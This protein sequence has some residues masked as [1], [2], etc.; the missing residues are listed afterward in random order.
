MTPAHVTLYPKATHTH[1]HTHTQSHMHPCPH[2]CRKTSSMLCVH[3]HRGQMPSISVNGL[4]QIAPQPS[5]AAG[6]QTAQAGHDPSKEIWPIQGAALITWVDVLV[7]GG[8]VDEP[9][10]WADR[11]HPAAHCRYAV[12]STV[13]CPAATAATA[14]VEAQGSMPHRPI[15]SKLPSALAGAPPNSSARASSGSSFRAAT[16]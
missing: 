8:R 1:T 16:G 4:E 13:G 6:K 11:A 3:T 15:S 10:E 5:V 14:A 9:S 12:C 2:Q 7:Y